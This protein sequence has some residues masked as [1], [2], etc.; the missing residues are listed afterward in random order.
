M[1]FVCVLTLHCGLHHHQRLC[2]RRPGERATLKY[3]QTETRASE[4]GKLEQSRHG[5][6]WQG[7]AAAEQGQGSTGAVGYIR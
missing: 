7:R 3:K 4:R 1:P 5:R 2:H 6:T